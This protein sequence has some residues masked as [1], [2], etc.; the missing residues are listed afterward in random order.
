MVP[1]INNPTQ[2]RVNTKNLLNKK[3]S[4]YDIKN[5]DN[6][7]L[8][9]EKGIYNRAIEISSELNVVKKWNNEFF[10]RIYIDKYKSVYFNLNND[11]VIQYI[12]DNPLN[13]HHIAFMSHQELKPE[14][15]HNLIEKK[16]LKEKD[17]YEPTILASTDDFTCRKCKSK[18]CTYYQLQTRSADE[19]MTTYVTCISCGKRWKC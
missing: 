11:D 19:P 4:E 15:W 16:K 8:N 3:L 10:V 13:V 17:L 2:F 7:S 1:K 12:R 14:H 5:V 18:E 6:V 9:I